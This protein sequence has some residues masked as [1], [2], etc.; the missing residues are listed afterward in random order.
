MATP[1]LSRLS[2]RGTPFRI[3]KPRSIGSNA[4]TSGACEGKNLRDC[5]SAFSS[6]LLR[7][8]GIACTGLLSR[9]PA[10]KGRLLRWRWRGKKDNKQPRQDTP[11]ENYKRPRAGVFIEPFHRHLPKKHGGMLAHAASHQGLLVFYVRLSTSSSPPTGGKGG[12][13][14]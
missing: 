10:F 2:F 1:K 14:P 8:P 6:F 11:N 7:S 13:P 3:R 12:M 9:L 5:R 4:P